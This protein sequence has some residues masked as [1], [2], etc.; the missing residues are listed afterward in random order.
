V[1]EQ[2]SRIRPIGVIHSPFR[3]ASGTPIQAA[4]A[5]DAEG[6]VEIFPEFADGL[7]D[8]DRFT[9]LFLLYL[10]HRAGP[11]RLSCVPFLDDRERGVFATRAPCRP[12]P[13]GLTIV[14]LIS[15]EGRRIRVR[16][17]DVVDGTPLLDLKPYVP[18]FD[19]RPEAGSGW[20]GD[21]NGQRLEGRA[22]DRFEG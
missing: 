14:R 7:R 19:C 16:E 21:I 22:D 8:V 15:L 11:T 6:T 10:F 1:N 9:H 18:R 17:L 12:N 5:S 20:V 4:L 3:E 13:I 2:A